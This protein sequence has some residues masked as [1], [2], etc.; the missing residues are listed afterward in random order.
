M[1]SDKITSG[2][3]T[4]GLR[5]PN[6]SLTL[7]LIRKLGHPV[8]A[9]S[10]NKFTKTSPTSAQH[11]QTEFPE[12]FTLDGGTCEIG[13]EST[14]VGFE[15]NAAV[16]YRPGMISASEIEK[17]LGYEIMTKES[18]VAPGHLK[19][20]YMPKKPIIALLDEVDEQALSEFCPPDV[21]EQI[22]YWSLPNDPVMAARVLYA[23]FREFDHK[24]ISAIGIK[25]TQEQRS[26]VQY[27]G[28]FNRLFKAASYILPKEIAHNP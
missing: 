2:L 15:N 26:N 27:S 13:I 20:H 11:V 7:E 3:E 28:I 4:V 19:H 14:I 10:A 1:I 25:F 22:Y 12:V 21:L 16:I 9:P 5:I 18:P 23:K 17:C 8:A 24:E 6:H